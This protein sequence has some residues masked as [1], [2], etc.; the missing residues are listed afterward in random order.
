VPVTIVPTVTANGTSYSFVDTAP[1]GSFTYSVQ[2]ISAGGTSAMTA[3][4]MA[5]TAP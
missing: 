4:S 5:V 1:A 2:A 3:A